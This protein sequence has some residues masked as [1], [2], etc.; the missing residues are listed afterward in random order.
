MIY[1]TAETII[2]KLIDFVSLTPNRAEWNEE[3]I[4]SNLPRYIRYKRLISLIKA[5]NLN[6]SIEGLYD[7]YFLRKKNIFKKARYFNKLNENKYFQ[8]EI[9]RIK[10]LIPNYKKEINVYDEYLNYKLWQHLLRLATHII[11]F[12]NDT[13]Y[14]SPN[15]VGDK[16]ALELIHSFYTK[17]NLEQ[18]KKIHTILGIL[19][20]PE[21]RIISLTTLI[22][23]FNYP[24]DDLA[25]IDAEWY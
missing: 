20:D 24:D 25:Q 21:Q 5:F 18:V 6:C 16:Y 19:M 2:P 8:D 17:N 15:I 22:N 11:K 23:S 13:K 3:K 14:L 7:G 1:Y 10:K 9:N 4:K 12:K